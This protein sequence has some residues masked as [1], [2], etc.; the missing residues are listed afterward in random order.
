MKI[1][2]ARVSR[3]TQTLRSQVDLLIK[4][5]CVMI[6]S[7]KDSGANINR[8][9]LQN[10]LEFLKEGDTLVI[11]HID[12][13]SR[14]AKDTKDINA[15]LKER[16]IKLFVLTDPTMETD[17]AHGKLV[18]GIKAE[19]A[20]HQRNLDIEK[21]K[22][23]LASARARGKHGGKAFALT[24]EQMI[25][26]AKMHADPE[27]SIA[28]LCRTF[29]L[30]KHAIYKYVRRAKAA[31]VYPGHEVNIPIIPERMARK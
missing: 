22:D 20:E 21:I 26:L 11:Y 12:R 19:I 31:G 8:K 27:N 4:A 13:L 29:K 9:E 5:G 17:T 1:G 16:G 28:M 10:C 2:Y 18:F 14:I 23:G 7:E 6:F 24:L 25:A 30:K 15:K 3:P